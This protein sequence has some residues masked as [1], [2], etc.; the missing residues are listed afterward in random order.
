MKRV[1]TI[2]V[3]VVLA[4]TSVAAEAQPKGGEVQ[5]DHLPLGTI[6]TGALV[7]GSFMVFEAGTN[8]DIPFSVIVPRFAK[9]RHKSTH[10]QEYGKG[11]D[12]I[13]G[14]IEFTVDTSA[15]GDL[16]GEFGVTLG[17]AVVKI[18]ISAVVKPVH[19]GLTKLLITETPF[20]KYSTGDGKHFKAWTD[21][22]NDASLDVSYLQ[23]T[24]G[25]L[26]LRDLD[27]SQFD[28]ILLG[29]TGLIELQDS[30]I[31]RAREYA[32]GGGRVVVA[33]NRFFVG[34][35]EKANSV[36]DGYGIQIWDQESRDAQ[37]SVTVQQ[38]DLSP[39]LVKSGVKSASFSRVSPVTITDDKLGQ[40]LVKAG[41]GGRPGDGFVG[42]A[43][44]GK[45]EVV[46]LGQSLWWNWIAKG[47]EAGADNAQLL[48]CLLVP[49]KD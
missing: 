39:R 27:L 45:G 8:P 10:H 34:T 19:K 31:K 35:V 44:A 26:V 36:L 41:R 42:S 46:A 49:Q 32:E 33:A 5:P 40:L 43:K 17:N 18:P 12:F 30:D 48:R 20:E 23:V 1:G 22:V 15:A 13:C 9:L 6:Y 24:R 4:L 11:K 28:C 25:K 29:G 21:L 2:V 38:S 7:E 3:A 37:K 14:A 16:S 47:Q